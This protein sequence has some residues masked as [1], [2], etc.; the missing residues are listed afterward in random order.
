MLEIVNS[1]E[2]IAEVMNLLLNIINKYLMDRYNF[3]QALY[4][5]V[6]YKNPVEWAHPKEWGEILLIRFDWSWVIL[7]VF[8]KKLFVVF[9]SDAAGNTASYNFYIIADCWFVSVSYEK[10]LAN[11]RSIVFFDYKGIR[12]KRFEFI[13]FAI[14]K[15][16]YFQIMIQ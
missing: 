7:F 5:R 12:K 13:W 6:S 4:R 8:P 14:F 2:R 16:L 3:L 11:A 15:E 9:S 10:Y 1:K